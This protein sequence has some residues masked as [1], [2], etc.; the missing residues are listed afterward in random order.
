MEQKLIDHGINIISKMGHVD[1]NA[2]NIFTDIIYSQLFKGI[3]D[4]G[5]GLRS[6]MDRAI[7]NLQD[8]IDDMQNKNKLF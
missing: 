4:Q 5:K 3:L 6:D 1:V 2:D 8:K 7:N